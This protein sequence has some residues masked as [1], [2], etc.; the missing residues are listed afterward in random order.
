[1]LNLD[2]DR[3]ASFFAAFFDL[4]VAAQQ[5]YLTG[6]TD[7]TGTMH[8]MQKL[9]LAAPPDIRRTM[10]ASVVS[11]RNYSQDRKVSTIMGS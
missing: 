2:A 11:S 3:T 9:F 6:R 5:A 4:P 7:L 10:A 8:T 1:M